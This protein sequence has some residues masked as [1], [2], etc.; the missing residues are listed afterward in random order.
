MN[1][2]LLELTATSEPVL[3]ISLFFSLL[4]V[5]IMIGLRL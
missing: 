3:D 5:I 4:I 2:G 1:Y